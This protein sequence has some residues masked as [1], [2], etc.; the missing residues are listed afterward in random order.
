MLRVASQASTIFLAVMSTQR[1]LVHKSKGVFEVRNDAPLPRLRDDY[2]IVTTKAVAL[3]PT[4]WKSATNRPSPGAI[5]GCDYSGIVEQVGSKVTTPFKVGD[6]V[7]GFVRGGDPDE[8]E[9]GAFAEHIA[10]KGDMQ[11]RVGDNISF[12][13]AATLGVGV[14]TVGQGLYQSLGLP[15]PPAKVQEPTSILIYGGSTATGV[16]A[17][18]YAKLYVYA[19][20]ISL[21]K[22]TVI[23]PDAKSSQLHPPIITTSAKS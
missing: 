7:A 1:A 23:V 12:E 15:L 21:I 20:E 9:N 14:T 22:L 10:A 4:D 19:G 5:A 17:I 8:H 18:Q 11:M 6:R 16:L 3:N 2:I 13:E